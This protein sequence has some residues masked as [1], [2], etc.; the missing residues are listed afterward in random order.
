[1]TATAG[2]LSGYQDAA[3][4]CGT[5]FVRAPQGCARTKHP[6]A[7]AVAIRLSLECMSLGG[8]AKITGSCRA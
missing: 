4:R 2:Q 6:L 8:E 7:D 5:S 3:R 1:M